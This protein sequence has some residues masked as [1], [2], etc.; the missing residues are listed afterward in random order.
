MREVREE[1]SVSLSKT[2]LQI[3]TYFPHDRN[4]VYLCRVPQE[5]VP[6]LGEGADM[7]WVTLQEM[8]SMELGFHQN[9]L[10]EIIKKD[11]E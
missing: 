9:N 8:L 1:Y 5:C 7:K 4:V 3:L 2:D 6:I 11:L 10:L